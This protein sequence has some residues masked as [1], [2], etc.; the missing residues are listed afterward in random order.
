M[1]VYN[2]MYVVIVHIKIACGSESED[3]LGLPLVRHFFA[4]LLEELCL[5]PHVCT[6]NT[7]S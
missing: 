6:V 1:Y 4:F 7:Y 2:S 3:Y 5:M